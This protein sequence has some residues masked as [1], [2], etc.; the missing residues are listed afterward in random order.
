MAALAKQA[1]YSSS[2]VVVRAHCCSTVRHC[3][4]RRRSLQR[5]CANKCECSSTAIAQPIALAQRRHS[6]SRHSAAAAAL[7]TELAMAA[8]AAAETAAAAVGATVLLTILRSQCVC[9]DGSNRRLAA[10]FLCRHSR[11]RLCSSKL[12]LT[13]SEISFFPCHQTKNLIKRTTQ[14]TQ[15]YAL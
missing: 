4:R 8:T 10:S 11:L 6:A 1:H 15:N 3:R 7:P 13:F 12:L 5:V 2:R 9:Y 14:F